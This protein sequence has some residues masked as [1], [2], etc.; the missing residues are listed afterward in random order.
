VEARGREPRR[1]YLGGANAMRGTACGVR[2]T[3]ARTVRTLR[4]HESSK[5]SVSGSSELAPKARRTAR[6]EKR[7]GWRRGET[8]ESETQGRYRHETRP[9]RSREEQGVKRL[10]KPEDAAQPGQASPV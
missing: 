1:E 5:P 9:E 10:R 8:S 4:L 2:V 7:G 6:A 3:L